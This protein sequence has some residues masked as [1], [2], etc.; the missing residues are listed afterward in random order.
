MSAFDVRGAIAQAKQSGPN[1]TESVKAGGYEPPAAGFVKLRFVAY[2]EVGQHEVEFDNKKKVEDQVHLVFELSGKNHAPREFDGEKVPQRMTLR[3]KKSL[4]E[5]ANFFK[6]FS[7]MNYEGK[8]THI[9]ELLGQDFVGT[10]EH[11]KVKDKTYANLKDVRKPFAQIVDAEG[12]VSEQRVSVD[13]PLTALGLFLWD[14]ATTEMWDA[15]FIAGEWEAEEKDGKV[16]REA[17]SKNVIQ[18]KIKSALN[19]KALPIFDYAVGKANA[20]DS[21]ALADAVGEAEAP[22]RAANDASDPLA[23]VA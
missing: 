19:F 10:I 18:D 17:R 23:G 11:K 16:I 21:A 22:T 7:G 15:I 9:A 2:Y 14:F 5:K 13:P 1:M 20:A 3:I 4:N 6:L 12:E 8:A